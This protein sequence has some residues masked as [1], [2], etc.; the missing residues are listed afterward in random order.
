MDIKVFLAEDD[1]L[2]KIDVA[3]V[4]HNINCLVWNVRKELLK[5][6]AMNYTKEEMLND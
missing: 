4:W 6:A 2:L 5:Q 3:V 1:P